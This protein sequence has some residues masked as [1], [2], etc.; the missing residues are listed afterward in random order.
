MLSHPE[1]TIKS[2]EINR[3]QNL[4]Q[5]IDMHANDA[6]ANEICEELQTASEQCIA[7]RRRS[8]MFYSLLA[9]LDAYLYPLNEELK[10][11]IAEEGTDYSQYTEQSKKTVAAVVSTV[12]SIKAVLDT[13]ILT[14][15]G[16]ITPESGELVDNM[17]K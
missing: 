3:N 12:A 17:T 13:T 7:I 16:E 6:K 8:Y 5:Q 10:R 2:I 11:I 1:G 15:S 14:E 9:K 4:I